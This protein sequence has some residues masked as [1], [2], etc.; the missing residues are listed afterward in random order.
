MLAI[1]EANKRQSNQ[2]SK[3]GEEQNKLAINKEAKTKKRR[4][5]SKKQGRW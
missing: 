5:A 3:L 1:K 2:R 4:H